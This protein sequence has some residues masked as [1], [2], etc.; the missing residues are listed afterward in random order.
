MSQWRLVATFR[1]SCRSSA[2]LANR[3][4]LIVSLFAAPAFEVSSSYFLGRVLGSPSPAGIVLRG[5][6]LSV[7]LT[8]AT[9]IVAAFAHDRETGVLAQIFSHRRLDPQYVTGVVL[10]AATLATASGFINLMCLLLI[11]PVG[12]SIVAVIELLPLAL[13]AGTALGLLCSFAVFLLTDPYAALN[14]FVPLLPLGVGILVPLSEY[15]HPVERLL[16]FVPPASSLERI[17]PNAHVFVISDYIISL[18]LLVCGLMLMR[19]AAGRFRSTGLL[20]HA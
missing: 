3:R 10:A 9:F 16:R 17:H 8:T 5:L 1:L 7:L 11:F 12:S 2:V 18:V 4:T 15:P 13:V 20:L 19:W 6:V 14:L